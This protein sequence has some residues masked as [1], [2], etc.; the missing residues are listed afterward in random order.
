MPVTSMITTPSLTQHLEPGNNT[1]KGFAYSGG[2]RGIVRV[3][4]S[5]D[6]GNIVC[7]LM[8]AFA[9]VIKYIYKY[10]Y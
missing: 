6:A 2:G 8:H 10:L 4:V 7:C 3:D 5:I 1:L 9:F